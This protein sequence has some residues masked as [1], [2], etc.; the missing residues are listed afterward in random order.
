MSGGKEDPIMID[1]SE[2]PR[3]FGKKKLPVHYTSD[4]SAWMTCPTFEDYRL[5][6]NKKLDPEI[7][8]LVDNCSARKTI[9]PLQNIRLLRIYI[10]V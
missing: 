8:I 5:T 9:I 2:N 6:W 3:C 7:L 10:N 4:K 1:E